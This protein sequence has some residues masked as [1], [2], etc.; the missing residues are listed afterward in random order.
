MAVYCLLVNAMMLP[1]KSINM[2]VIVGILR[3]GGDTRF[4]MFAEM[5]GVWAIGVP[6]AFLGVLVLD[7]NIWQVYLLLGMEE[8][9]KMMISMVR[10]LRGKWITDLT[11]VH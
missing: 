11:A 4:S 8:L 3:A 7:L 5:F 1:L 9:T 2:A 10:V 6:L